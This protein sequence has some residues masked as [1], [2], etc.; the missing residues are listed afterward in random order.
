MLQKMFVVKK[1]TQ[2][3]VPVGTEKTDQGNRRKLGLA[4]IA[5]ENKDF[6]DDLINLLNDFRDVITIKDEKLGTCNIA[7]HEI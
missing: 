7:K 4:D 3:V 1:L 6:A 2:L 5:I